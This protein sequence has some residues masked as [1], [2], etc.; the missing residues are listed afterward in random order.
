MA[1]RSGWLALIDPDDRHPDLAS[2][3]ASVDPLAH[4]R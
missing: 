4:G 2:A 1:R 3:L